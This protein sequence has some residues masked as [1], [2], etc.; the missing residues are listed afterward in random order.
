MKDF[1]GNANYL[2]APEIENVRR[3]Y[4]PIID[5][6]GPMFFFPPHC[7]KRKWWVDGRED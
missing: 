1:M 4:D 7:Y 2:G 3:V 5:F 6:L